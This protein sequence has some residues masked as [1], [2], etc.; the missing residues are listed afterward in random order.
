[1]LQIA[2][3]IKNCI[4]QAD[5][6]KKVAGNQQHATSKQFCNSSACAYYILA[7]KI[8]I[9]CQYDRRTN[10][11][12]SI[13]QPA[14]HSAKDLLQNKD[15]LPEEQRKAYALELF[16]FIKY[17]NANTTSVN[18]RANSPQCKP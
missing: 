16:G 18:T 5:M 4:L 12:L 8:A 11:D 17:L 14:Y 7:I 13:V 3:C 2:Q 6:F 10:S 9:D 1:M 15:N